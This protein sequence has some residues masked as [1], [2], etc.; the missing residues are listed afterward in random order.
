MEDDPGGYAR[1]VA[2]LIRDAALAVQ[3]VHD[4]NIVHRD[5]KPANLM[6]TPD[7]TRVVLMDF[8]L[9]KG[10]SLS[11]TASR[12]GGFLGTLRYAAPEQLAAATL[13]VGPQADVRALGR[14]ALGTAHPATSC[15]ARPR[16]RQQLATLGLR[17]G[18]AASA[19][20]GSHAGCRPGGHRRS[21]HGT[22][23]VANASRPPANWP[24]TWISTCRASRSRFGR[25]PH[26]KSS[27][28]GYGRTSSSYNG[29]CHGPAPPHHH[30]GFWTDQQRQTKPFSRKT[31]HFN[32][33]EQTR[34]WPVRRRKHAGVLVARRRANKARAEVEQANQSLA[35]SLQVSQRAT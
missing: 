19:H 4:Q 33:R 20:R 23:R 14:D 16:T 17:P 21:G 15:S 9:A 18:R 28:D 30:H 3:A 24:S 11:L 6:L 22:R 8:G 34:V 13:K 5:V 27:D 7:G 25:Q 35:Q 32:W 29:R 1:R 10:Q 26:K 2:L 12:A 31:A